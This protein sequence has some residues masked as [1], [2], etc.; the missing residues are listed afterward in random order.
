MVFGP[1]VSRGRRIVELTVILRQMPILAEGICSREDGSHEKTWSQEVDGRGRREA[2]S[3]YDTDEGL[4]ERLPVGTWHRAHPLPYLA[5][6]CRPSANPAQCL[7]GSV[8]SIPALCLRLHVYYSPSGFAHLR[9]SRFPVFGQRISCQDTGS[10]VA[11]ASLVAKI[12]PRSL[13]A[14]VTK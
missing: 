12:T 1:P 5:M 2:E 6:F 3:K 14:V 7:T 8:L 4:V 13:R 9:F 11:P 10:R